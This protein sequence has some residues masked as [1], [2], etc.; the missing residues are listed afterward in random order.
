MILK[1]YLARTFCGYKGTPRIF[2]GEAS[3]DGYLLWLLLDSQV[4]TWRATVNFLA[5]RITIEKELGSFRYRSSSASPYISKFPFAEY[6]RFVGVM[7]EFQKIVRWV[8]QEE[9]V[10]FNRGACE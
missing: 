7:L 1:G 8:F 10:V 6:R 5:M 9:G 4:E 2:E 3:E